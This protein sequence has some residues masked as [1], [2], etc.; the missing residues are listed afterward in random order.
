MHLGRRPSTFKWWRKVAI[1][2]VAMALTFSS[3]EQPPHAQGRR[4]ALV[5][6]VDLSDPGMGPTGDNEL[7]SR[8]TRGVGVERPLGAG[9][10]VAA[11][12]SADI[13]GIDGIDGFA[14]GQGVSGEQLLQGAGA[15]PRRPRG[16]LVRL[17]HMS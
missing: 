5:C 13:D 7:A 11:R 17:P 9:L 16:R 8:M 15:D 2:S 6:G 10:R 1:C 3:C 14:T 12:S 4:P